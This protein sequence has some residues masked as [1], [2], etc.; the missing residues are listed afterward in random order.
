MRDVRAYLYTGAATL[1]KPSIR[2]SH[3]FKS[4]EEGIEKYESLRP[5]YATSQVVFIEY[6]RAESSKIIHI[7][8]PDE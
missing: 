4:L 5:R 3:Q 8:H 1:R 7:L 6:F 2:K